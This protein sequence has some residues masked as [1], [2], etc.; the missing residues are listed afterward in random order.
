MIE[1]YGDYRQNCSGGRNCASSTRRPNRDVK[2]IG[3]LRS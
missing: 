1:L 3:R 2:T